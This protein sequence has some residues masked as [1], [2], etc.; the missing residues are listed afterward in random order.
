[1]I[2]INEM[3]LLVVLHT[4]VV[5]LAIQIDMLTPPPGPGV[6]AIAVLV[7]VELTML[8]VVVVYLAKISQIVDGIE[9]ELVAA[10][11]SPERETIR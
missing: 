1:M 8:V 3:L 2:K 6:M 10:G 11:W 9:K 7:V 4:D 5:F